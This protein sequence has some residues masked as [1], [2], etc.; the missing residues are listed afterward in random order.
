MRQQPK[1]H[2]AVNHA[3]MQVLEQCNDVAGSTARPSGVCKAGQLD[4]AA[5]L[6]LQSH[7]PVQLEC[8]IGHRHSR[9][10]APG[11]AGC[12][13]LLGRR[14]N[15]SYYP[16]ARHASG[17]HDCGQLY[18][19]SPCSGAQPH[20]TFPLHLLFAWIRCHPAVSLLFD[21]YC[22]PTHNIRTV[23]L[24]MLLWLTFVTPS[25]PARRSVEALSPRG[26]SDACS[27][28]FCT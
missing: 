2:T 27:F 12:P 25:D 16:L 15:L 14:G 7:H 3:G 11:A 6:R 8:G 23:V 26:C 20:P 5:R 1:C 9:A 28:L 13:H 21:V 17:L 19:P 18:P 24:L 4:W 22:P 10:V